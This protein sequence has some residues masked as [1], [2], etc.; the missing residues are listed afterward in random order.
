VD[1]NLLPIYPVTRQDILNA[2]AILGPDVGSLKGKMTRQTPRSVIVTRATNIPV[3]ILR[4]YR[5]VV[6]FADIMFVN[7]TAFF[8]SISRNIRFSTT[9][10][11]ENQRPDTIAS[12]AKQVIQLTSGVALQLHISLWMGSL[13]VFEESWQTTTLP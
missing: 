8:V 5:N 11:I 6:I 13:S 2:K 4:Q 3:T 1:R 7:K 12:A 10:M 9:E